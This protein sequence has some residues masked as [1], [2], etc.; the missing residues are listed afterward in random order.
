M[1]VKCC[2]CGQGGS[3][4]WPLRCLPPLMPFAEARWVHVW[5][6]GVWVMCGD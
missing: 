3:P 6:M 1:S 2:N 5:F 4:T